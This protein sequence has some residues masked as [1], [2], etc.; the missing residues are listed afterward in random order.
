M[1]KFRLLTEWES[2][3]FRKSLPLVFSLQWMNTKHCI[4]VKGAVDVTFAA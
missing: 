1:G 4:I 3:S 2:L